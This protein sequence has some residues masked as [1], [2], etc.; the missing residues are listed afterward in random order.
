MSDILT[1][2]HAADLIEQLSSELEQA[3]QVNSGLE[4]M[5]TSAQS[6]AETFKRQ[7]DAALRDWEHT[8]NNSFGC[9]CFGCKHFFENKNTCELPVEQRNYSFG[10]WEWR[11]LQE[12]P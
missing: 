2:M 12:E 1:L 9:S 5:M 3:Q 7:R 10:C 6:A 11:G 8:R 4:I